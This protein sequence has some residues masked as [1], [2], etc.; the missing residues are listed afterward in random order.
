MIDDKILLRF[1]TIEDIFFYLF[2]F[3]LYF[4]DNITN[5]AH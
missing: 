4:K 3:K 2:A 1:L 5:Q